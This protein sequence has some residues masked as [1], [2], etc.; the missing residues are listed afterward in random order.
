ME[1]E[2]EEKEAG[3]SAAG[4]HHSWQ[5]LL[6][7]HGNTKQC[8]L[9]S[10]LSSFIT[11]CSLSRSL[12]LPLSVPSLSLVDLPLALPRRCSESAAVLERRV[13]LIA[14]L[15]LFVL[16]SLK[17]KKLFV[18]FA[19]SHPTSP[20]G[21]GQPFGPSCRV[22]SEEVGR[23]WKNS[24]T[25]LLLFQSALMCSPLRRSETPLRGPNSTL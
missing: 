10:L 5:P 15:L 23:S 17:K 3:L 1:E 16:S 12:S 22:T 2:E 14:F 9:L 25:L 13:E 6:S 11:L 24:C 7:F 18:Y 21:K 19:T 20:P 4:F 8:S